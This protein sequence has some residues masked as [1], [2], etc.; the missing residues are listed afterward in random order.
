MGGRLLDRW[1][2]PKN[3]SLAVKHH[4]EPALAKNEIRL[5]SCV[6]LS[7]FLAYRIE[8]RT[9]LPDYALAPDE[10][11]LKELKLTRPELESLVPEAA[12]RFAA[13]QQRYM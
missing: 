5:T 8:N 1:G 13:A 3:I 7:N 10:N 12:E 9:T 4:H 6:C 2:F 11:A